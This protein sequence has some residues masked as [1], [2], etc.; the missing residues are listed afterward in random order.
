MQVP[1]SRVNGRAE[2]L[3]FKT[4]SSPKLDLIVLAYTFKNNTCICCNVSFYERILQF[5]K[6]GR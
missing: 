1:L 3:E 4:T 6:K 2:A 5:E